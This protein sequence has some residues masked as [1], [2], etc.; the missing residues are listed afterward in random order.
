MII[1]IVRMTLQENKCVEF[2][3]KFENWRSLISSVPGCMDLQLLGD[4]DNPAVFS[5]YSVWESQEFLDNYRK[6]DIFAEVWPQTKAYFAEKPL[7]WS[8]EVLH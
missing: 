1:R 5:T 2:R 8:S 6:S 7:A 4:V 3:S